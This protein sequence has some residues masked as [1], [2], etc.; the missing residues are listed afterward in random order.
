M[1][2][3]FDGDGGDDDE[4]VGYGKPP[5]RTRFKPGRSGNPKGRPKGSNNLRTDVRKSLKMPV[6]I[7]DA[8]GRRKVS[9]Q[10]ALILRLREQ[11]L[12][13]DSKARDRF[14]KLAEDHN[15]D[16]VESR[17]EETLAAE[18]HE[19]VAAFLRRRAA[20]GRDAAARKPR[21][22][23]RVNRKRKPK[24]RAKADRKPEDER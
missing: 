3:G 18:D 24:R 23:E 16:T 5:R 14:I 12:K 19:I 7:A 11:A 4:K 9:T 13:G 20:L 1:T 22:T 2:D 6:T 21:S 15:N 17:D 8:D 10:E